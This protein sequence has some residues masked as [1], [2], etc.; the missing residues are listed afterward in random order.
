ME[1]DGCVLFLP[2]LPEGSARIPIGNPVACIIGKRG[3]GGYEFMG[4]IRG[5][6]DGKTIFIIPL[7]E[8]AE[9]AIGIDGM[10]SEEREILADKIHLA[11]YT[12]S[13]SN[14]LISC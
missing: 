4:C 13:V 11:I 8:T 10:S 6:K 2:L 12:Y 3:G 1:K 7:T 14:S 9:T 5:G